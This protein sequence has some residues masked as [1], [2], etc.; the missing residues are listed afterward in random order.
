MTKENYSIRIII[1]VTRFKLEIELHNTFS[2]L[3]SRYELLDRREK[4]LI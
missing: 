3:T 1:T 4:Q 2:S